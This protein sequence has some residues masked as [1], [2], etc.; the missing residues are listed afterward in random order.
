M[1]T[2][3]LRRRSVAAAAFALTGLLALTACGGDSGDDSAA[4]TKVPGVKL[5]KNGKLTTCTSLPYPPFQFP[6]N[7]KVVGFD[8]DLI[9]KVAQKLGVTQ[10]IVD[11]KFDIIKSGAAL[12]SGRCDVAAA[13]MTITEERKKNL[14]FSTSYFPEAIALMTAKGKGVTTLEQVKSQN[15][16]LGVQTGTTS[17]DEAKKAGLKPKEFDDAGKQLLALQSGQ[18]DIILQDLPVVNDWLKK[19]DVA[20]KFE[21]TAEFETGMQYGFAVRKGGN[22][23]LLKVINDTISES[24]KDGSWRQL[25]VKWIGSEPKSTPNAQ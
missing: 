7:G 12:N 3:S 6:Q 17:L 22:P 1:T 13:G 25:Y 24:I 19:P 20:A 21:R 23:E 16:R 14:D 15:L 11:V 5:V 2:G 4:G 8:V 10:E 18:I 9:D